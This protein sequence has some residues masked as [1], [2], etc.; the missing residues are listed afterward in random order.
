VQI[1]FT[2]VTIRLEHVPGLEPRG[3]ALEV[4][5]AKLFYS[6]EHGGVA[7]GVPGA[8]SSTKKIFFEDVSLFTDDFT[9]SRYAIPNQHGP[10]CLVLY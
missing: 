3:L 1:R 9:F 8:G 10:R 7:G 5:I 6:G 4:H 2:N